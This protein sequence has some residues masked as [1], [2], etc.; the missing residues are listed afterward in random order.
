MTLGGVDIGKQSFVHLMID[1]ANRDPA[2][3]AEPDRLDITRAANHHLAFG[4]GAHFC[5]GA[6][7]SR[8]E[9]QVAFPTLLRRLPGLSLA[10]RPDELVWVSRNSPSRGLAALPIRY[11][12]RLPR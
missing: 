2:E 9:G 7:L 3:F 1:C 12:R 5:V 8:I 6:P 10:V 4:Q 11:D